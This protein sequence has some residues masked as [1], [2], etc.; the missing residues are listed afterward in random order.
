MKRK[1]RLQVGADADVVVFD[2][3]RVLDTATFDEPGKYSEGFRYVLVNGV[4]V[5]SDGRLR[6]GVSPGRPVRAPIQ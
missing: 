3:G 1:G 4:A 6:D 5:V 2:P